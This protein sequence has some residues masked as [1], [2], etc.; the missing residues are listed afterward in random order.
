MH[1]AARAARAPAGLSPLHARAFSSAAGGTVTEVS[2][3]LANG[4]TG[5]AG[6]RLCR[7]IEAGEEPLPQ[8]FDDVAHFRLFLR[9][10]GD[11]QK[12]RTLTNLGNM[13]RLLGMDRASVLSLLEHYGREFGIAPARRPPDVPLAEV[14]PGHAIFEDMMDLVR[15]DPPVLLPVLGHLLC[16]PAPWVEAM[17]AEHAPDILARPV[18]DRNMCIGRLGHLLT[19][20]PA[21][22]RESMVMLLST[23]L[24]LLS[25]AI[26][27]H[28][29]EYGDMNVPKMPAAKLEALRAALL[30][31]I[32]VPMATP[33]MVR[34]QADVSD[35]V[36]ARYGPELCAEY[37]VR[38]QGELPR[39]RVDQLRGLLQERRH[40]LTEM[41]KAM[42]MS[43]RL[44]RWY[45]KY[46]EPEV[47]FPITD[48]RPVRQITRPEGLGRLTLAEYTRRFLPATSPVHQTPAEGAPAPVAPVVNYRVACF[49]PREHGSGPGVHLQLLHPKVHPGL[50]TRL[51]SLAGLR[52]MLSRKEMCDRSG[53][54]EQTILK[55]MPLFEWPEGFWDSRRASQRYAL[56]DED[57]RRLRL[58]AKQVHPSGRRMRFTV[59]ELAAEM[60]QHPDV[61]FDMLYRYAPEYFF[62]ALGPEA[63][64]GPG[65]MY[66]PEGKLADLVAAVHGQKLRPVLHQVAADLGCALPQVVNSLRLHA[67]RQGVQFMAPDFMRHPASRAFH[68]EHILATYP[69]LPFSKASRHFED[70]PGHMCSHCRLF[71]L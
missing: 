54:A 6:E 58:L 52:P 65:G 26:D 45:I 18:W 29:P 28:F 44:L 8:G 62:L 5:S 37:M 3:A 14:G 38:L 53:L 40:S 1:A 36:F 11:P 25:L 49:N 2:R 33:T 71:L 68:V 13:G 27:K 63:G 19:V 35:W 22:S 66:V 55:S 48:D 64:S 10:I 56:A 51:Q 42:G 24:P 67:A 17:L 60:G 57:I 61:L 34:E 46:Y 59:R 69:N 4:G 30:E 9:L 41:A 31:G 43:S 21:L 20:E 47:I 7:A 16:M 50:H 15:R 12:H 39:E 32:R 23:S 70:M